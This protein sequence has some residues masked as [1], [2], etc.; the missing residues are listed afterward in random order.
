MDEIVAA[1]H[2]ATA[3]TER[4]HI[5]RSVMKI[6]KPGI[7][8][9]VVC[10]ALAALHSC[11]DSDHHSVSPK[12]PDDSMH[13]TKLVKSMHPPEPDESMFPKDPVEYPLDSDVPAEVRSRLSPWI[14]GFIG[15]TS[16]QAN[17]RLQERWS[18]IK[19]PSLQAL[20]ETLSKFEVKAIV[21]H[22]DGGMIY[23]FRPGSNEEEIGDIFFLPAP[24]EPDEIRRRLKPSGLD[25]NE[26]L[27]D[28]LHYFG[29]LAEDTTTAGHFVYGDPPWPLFTDSGDGE[30]EGFEDWKNALMLYHAR[31]GC[32]ILVRPDGK[33]A[34]WVMQEG[35]IATEAE[36][37]DEF[38]MKFN[39]HRKISW[40]YDPYGAPDDE[41]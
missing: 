1:P 26:A 38:V 2:K 10:G 22:G 13:P 5:G 17:E 6:W 15:L 25:E 12:E 30:I 28:F 32:F 19:R 36:N 20:R 24:L 3:M 40:P 35:K 37:F 9:V 16:A 23:A 14:A 18:P 27:R 4:H 34:W 39:E 41:K 8:L 29:G 31:N 21:D 33:V 11:N 7:K